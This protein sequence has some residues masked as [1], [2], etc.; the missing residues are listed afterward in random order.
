MP[1][2]KPVRN[3]PRDELHREY[4]L[5]LPDWDGKLTKSFG[6]QNSDHTAGVAVLD[7]AGKIV[8]IY[9]GKNLAAESMA[10]LA[11]VSGE[12]T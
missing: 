6:I 11:K 12:I 9:Q 10:L 1:T 5:L 2:M 3:S 7:S 4:L 8:G